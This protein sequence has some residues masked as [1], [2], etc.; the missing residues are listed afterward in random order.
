MRKLVLIALLLPATLA[1]AEEKAA[2]PS[3][4]DPMAG[5][6][7]KKVTRDAQDRKEIAAFIQMMDDAGR[8]GD[9]AAATALVDF[10]VLM[11]TDDSKGQASAVPWSREQWTQAME[12]FYKN[13]MGGKVTHRPTVFL[14]SDSLATLNDVVTMTMGK[15]SMTSRNT[16]IL[17]RK[18]GKW[19]V[20]VMMEGG[21]GDMMATLP[22]QTP[23]QG[24][25]ASPN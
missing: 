10:P 21:W 13:P 3:A 4:A 1:S 19:L 22:Q 11:V 6:T 12:P 24:A 7:P 8:K 18:D 25:P 14:A 16:S 2:A 9:L 20:K 15:R 5:W 17:V 23:A